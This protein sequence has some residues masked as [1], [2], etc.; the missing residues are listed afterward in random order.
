[1][2][3]PRPA[4]RLPGAVRRRVVVTGLAAVVAMMVGA[5]GSSSDSG[6]AASSGS[7]KKD[8]IVIGMS[9]PLT[10]PV[11]DR[12]KPGYEGYQ[13][14]VD[15]LNA[16]GGMLGRQVKLKVLDDG[17]DQK[18]AISDYTKLIGQDKV[19][20]VLGT[21]SSDLNLAV[22]PI[23][24]RYKYVYVEPSGGADEIFE[25]GFTKLF[26][27]QPATTKKL[28]EQFVKMIEEAPEA[29]RPKTVAYVTVEDPNT[30]QL[31]KILKADLEALGLETV[32]SATYAADASNFDAI[33]NAVKEAKP[34]LVVSGSIAQDGIQLIRSFQKLGF[35]P[36]ML[37]QTNTP[38]DPAFA[39]AI[40][41]DSTEGI[42]TYLAYSAEAG[43]PGND[44]FVSG[45]EEK[46]GAPPSED[47]ANSY[48]AGQVLAAGVEGAGSLD[49]EAIAKWLHAN[50]VDTIVGPLSWDAAGASQGHMLLAQ[51]QKGELRVIGPADAATT[52]EIVYEKPAW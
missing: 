12:A 22:A 33:A 29:Q 44:A 48:T 36:K 47:A 52:K 26:F 42:L 30:T 39:K 49:Q 25:R 32:H 20:L 14:W 40:G 9:L 43:Y 16:N 38:T 19:D 24:E 34:D 1:M 31:E 13:Y 8:P 37:Y 18:T 6:S 46:F 41:K 23:A 11:A 27:A 51:F 50:S 28:P 15:E 3:A 35:S 2:N 45:Y 7:A 17:F 10:G 21:F 4:R 5:C